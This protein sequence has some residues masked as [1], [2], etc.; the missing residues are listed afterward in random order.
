MRA[1]VIRRID[2]WGPQTSTKLEDRGVWD[3]DR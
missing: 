1:K 2:V 3:R